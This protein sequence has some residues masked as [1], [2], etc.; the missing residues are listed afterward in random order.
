MAE[1]M[2]SMVVNARIT[3][4]RDGKRVTPE[5]GKTFDFTAE[6]VEA[7]N[8]TLP[9]GIRK[10]INESKADAEDDSAAKGPAVSKAAANTSK[11][12]GKADASTPK[13]PV[14]AAGPESGEDADADDEAGDEDEDI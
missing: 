12:K 6:E 10:P 8:A 5:I 2:T 3:V 13:K 7:M 9:G 14:P 4:V 11:A 1:K